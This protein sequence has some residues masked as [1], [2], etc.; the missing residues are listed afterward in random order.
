[1][2]S[3]QRIVAACLIGL[4]AAL[5]LVGIVSGTLLR[6]IVQI[7]PTVLALVLVIRRP[8]VG[9]YA[10]TP[11]FMFW[12]CIVVLI[13]L[14]LLGLS[15]IASG[16]FTPIEIIS[17][18]FMAGFSLVGAIKSISLGKA[19]GPRGRLLTFLLLAGVQVGAMWVSFLR[20]IANRSLGTQ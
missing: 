2:T 9:A 18:F 17:T 15:G 13:W 4:G 3:H 6:H 16:H 19:L 1:M 8:N 14:F 5:L 12:I 20:P 7:I 10:A 11:V